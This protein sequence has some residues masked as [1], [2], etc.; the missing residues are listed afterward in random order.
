[1]QTYSGLQTKYIFVFLY[2]QHPWKKM[3]LEPSVKLS[4]VG[5]Q[6]P[7]DAF[8]EKIQEPLTHVANC[9]DTRG[10]QFYQRF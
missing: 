10:G 1:M 3:V 2:G 4:M 6:E 7:R 5:L 9:S 8:A